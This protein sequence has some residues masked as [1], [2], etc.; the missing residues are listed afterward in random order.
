[1]FLTSNCNY[2]S[3]VIRNTY[4]PLSPG[5]LLWEFKTHS[6]IV[7]SPSIGAFGI[8]YI[9]TTDGRLY[10]INTDGTKRWEFDAGGRINSSPVIGLDGTIYISTFT[11]KLYAI[12]ISGN[13]IR[14]QNLNNANGSAGEPAIGTDG[15]VIINTH[16]GLNSYSSQL[17][18]NWT[19]RSIR[20]YFF[21]CTKGS[22][23]AISYD[24][25]IYTG[26]YTDSSGISY[27][28]I[29]VNMQGVFLIDVNLPS[30]PT[31][32]ATIGRDGCIY[33][34]CNNGIL[35]ALNCNLQINWSRSIGEVN[36]KNFNR[37][38]IINSHDNIFFGNA[39]NNSL[40][41]ISKNG[42]IIWE[43]YFEE[44]PIENQSAAVLYDRS[45]Y[46]SS[47]R[48]FYSIDNAGNLNWKTSLQEKLNTSCVIANDGKIFVSSSEEGILYCLNSYL[49]PDNSSWPMF[50][51]DRRHTARQN[52]IE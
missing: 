17:N 3:N 42:N 8:V 10:A 9:T 30:L 43:F 27:K 52:F 25:V 29:S 33:I 48:T 46:F 13:L 2:E 45:V 36:T 44:G 51:H 15:S 6:S 20:N 5:Y 4:P 38:A 34:A 31:N 22:S 23:P 1:M 12:D 26:G 50:R 24:G 32:S 28:L 35:Y 41:S 19:L 47:G 37:T 16:D 49:P 11:D 40:M 39:V 21:H 7:S 18:L 14:Q